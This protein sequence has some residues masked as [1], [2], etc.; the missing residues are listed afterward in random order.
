M[1]KPV[2]ILCEDVAQ[3]NFTRRLVQRRGY[4]NRDIYME[5]LP[6]GKGAGDRHVLRHYPKH[7]E[8]VRRE[9]A[10][11]R[12]CLVVA[13]DADRYTVDQRY[14]QLDRALSECEDLREDRR[15]PRG[16]QEPIAVFMPK[17]HMETWIDYL[18]DG[19]PVS[20]EEQSQRHGKVELRQCRE[21]ADRFFELARKDSVPA[22]CPPSLARGLDELPRIR[23]ANG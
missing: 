22:D 16:S 5:A 4:S 23:E 2:V 13:I 18:L 20:E 12:R 1:S 21:A 6:V 17:W 3:Q 11:R 15:R 8:S 19:G 14:Q 10:Y 9:S 7:V